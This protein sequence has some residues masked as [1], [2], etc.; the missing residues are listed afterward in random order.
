[1]RK[2]TFLAFLSVFCVLLGL[3]S[4]Q[5]GVLEFLF[6]SLKKPTY[7]PYQTLEAPFA[8]N[9]SKPED[10][11]LEERLSQRPEDAVALDQPHIAHSA[12][13]DWVVTAVS[14]AMTF[15]AVDYRQDLQENMGYFDKPG[16][17]QFQKFLKST[18]LGK[19]LVS[20]KYHL[21][22]FVEHDPSLLNRGAAKGTYHWL[23]EVP[24][25]VTYMD[26]RMKDY[27]GA[28]PLSQRMDLRVQ[29]GRVR[30]RNAPY[31]LQIEHWSGTLKKAE[32]R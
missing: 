9:P 19:V 4:A 22:S 26:R 10:V 23:F 28:R 25:M 13:S 21:R 6:P 8:D 3:S 29:V 1:M 14:N 18:S 15:D 20:N 2:T 31:S 16:H 30:D 12:V 32:D 17:E 5:A 7:D 24:V 27:K 11:D